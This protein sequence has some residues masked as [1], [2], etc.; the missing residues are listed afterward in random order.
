MQLLIELRKIDVEA[1]QFDEGIVVLAMLK[2][3]RKEYE[4]ESIPLPEWLVQKI[5][6]LQREVK[7]R[8]RDYLAAA[9]LRAKTARDTLKTRDEKVKDLDGEI[10]RL[11]AALKQ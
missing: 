11:D 9:L 1:I 10:A 8:H 6:S 3:V 5:A 2:L 4:D 7:I